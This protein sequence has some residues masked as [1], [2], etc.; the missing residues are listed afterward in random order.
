MY[1]VLARKWRP[2]G[3]DELIGQDHVARTLRNAF[4]AGRIAHAYLFAGVRGTGKTT[5]ARILA[6]SLNCEKGPT[7][8]PCGTC[9]PCL[10]IAEGRAL[11]VLEIDAASRT[12]VDDIRELQEVVVYAPARD[13]YK[14]LIVDEVHMLSK[15]AFN[16]LL[17]TLEEPPPRVVFVLATTE[18]HK[19]LPTILSRCQTFE[20]RRVPPREVAAHLRKVCDAEKIVVSEK[21]LD[22]VARAGEGSVRDALSVLERVLAFCGSEIA[23]E[24]AFSLLGSVKT[25]VL[26][27]LVSA[28]VARD[29]AGALRTFDE[30]IRAGHDLLQFWAEFVSVARDLA[31]LSVTPDGGELLARPADESRAIADAAGGWSTD[32]RVRALQIL[33][34]LEPALRGASQP[35]FVFEACLLRLATLGDLR[36]VEDLLAELRG[37]DP[38]G[39]AAPSGGRPT[40]SPTPG[41]PF[42]PRPAPAPPDPKPP[43]KP[44]AG[45]AAPPPSKPGGPRRVEDLVE[46]LRARRPMLEAMLEEAATLRL[47]GDDVVVAFSPGAEAVRRMFER[48]DTVAFVR[49]LA[50]EVFGSSLGLRFESGDVAAAVPA[51][52]SATAGP[53]ASPT[54][55]PDETSSDPAPTRQQLFDGARR[56][57]SIQRLLREFGAQIVDVRPLELPRAEPSLGEDLPG[58]GEENA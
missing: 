32:D 42:V 22:R 29:A 12:G 30:V 10:E 27:G 1:Q 14:V 3:L 46:A 45:P 9:V 13:R 54:V 51:S 47:E 34:D 58:A 38:P 18:L 28:L 40:P 39:G 8:N 5:V 33:L 50:V 56:D 41:T 2:R 21:T 36:S 23:D 20:F 26:A 25:E 35:R 43:P 16:A 15:S 57:P 55:S 52:A 44:P 37:D 17:K 49:Q 31:V 4:G 7:A 48:D 53:A 11:D 6:K 19:V 24:D